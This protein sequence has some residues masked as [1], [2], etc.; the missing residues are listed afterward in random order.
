MDKKSVLSF[1]SAKSTGLRPKIDKMLTALD[2]SKFILTEE[3]TGLVKET[4]FFN[5]L[6]CM[7]ISISD[8]DQ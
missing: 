7:N 2:E 4:A 8:V 5:L 3:N 6:E 1:S